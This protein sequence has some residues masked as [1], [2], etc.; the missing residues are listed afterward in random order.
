MQTPKIDEYL[1]SII[2]V[3]DTIRDKL[4]PHVLAQ[5]DTMALL[6]QEVRRIDSSIGDALG[7][8]EEIEQA[9]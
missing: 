1:S 2:Q 4:T 3:A 8:I 6:L 5:S 7:T 9:T